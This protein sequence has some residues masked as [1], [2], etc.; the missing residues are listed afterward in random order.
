MNSNALVVVGTPENNLIGILAFID[1]QTKGQ[2]GEDYEILDTF[3][4][5]YACSDKNKDVHKDLTPYISE[6]LT[7]VGGRND[8]G[9]TLVEILELLDTTDVYLGGAEGCT[10]VSEICSGL[11][12]SGFK[13]HML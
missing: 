6:E 8:A 10:E 4:I 3:P 1:T 7:F 2:G 5:L 12:D 13:V 11:R 9:Q